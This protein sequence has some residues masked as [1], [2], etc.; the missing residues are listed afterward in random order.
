MGDSHKKEAI[1]VL[2]TD[3][4]KAL[5]VI[6]ALSDEYSRKIVLSIISSSLPIEEIAREQDI[7]MSTC[8][9]RIHEMLKFGIIRPDRTII[10][11]DGKKFVCYKSAIKNA[12]ILLDSGQLKV[13]VVVNKDPAE[14]LGAMWINVRNSA[15]ASGEVVS[16]VVNSPT[17][18]V[19]KIAPLITA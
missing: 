13:D 14:K 1:A 17:V 4:S 8:Y 5:E 15:S 19:Q 7:P 2:V 12:T 16:K 11:G 9:R 6:K 10:R 3:E 18:A